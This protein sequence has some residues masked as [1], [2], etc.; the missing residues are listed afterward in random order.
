MIT[1]ISR[2]TLF[3]DDQQQAKDFWVKKMGFHVVEEQN[4]S[5]WHRRTVPS[6]LYCMIKN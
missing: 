6:A 1:N 5:R 4:G 2:I 3:V